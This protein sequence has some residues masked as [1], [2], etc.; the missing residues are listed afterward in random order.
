VSG[1]LNYRIQ[2]LTDLGFKTKELAELM[3]LDS[4]EESDHGQSVRETFPLSD[5]FL[6]VDSW[7][8]NEIDPQVDR[9][10]SAVFGDTILTPTSH[11]RAMHDASSAANNSACLS[12]QV[13]AA[14]TDSGGKLL[15]VGWNDVPKFG[16][17]LYTS[18]DIATG[19]DHRCMAING[20]ICHNDHQKHLFAER[21]VNDLNKSD[22]IGLNQREEFKSAILKSKVRDLIEF[23]RSVHAEMHAI[24]NA[25]QASGDQMRGG[26][27]YCTTYPCHSCARHIVAA[28]LSEVHYIE[29]YRKSLATDLHRDAITEDEND[30]SKLRLLT[31]KGVAP[32]K[33]DDFFKA[34][35]NSRK[36]DGKMALD[37]AINAEPLVKASLEAIPQ[38]EAFITSDLVQKEL[39]EAPR[40]D[41]D[42]ET[43]D[44]PEPDIL[45]ISSRGD[46]PKKPS[47]EAKSEGKVSLAFL[48]HIKSQ[49]EAERNRI[50]SLMLHSVEHLRNI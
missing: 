7:Q 42:E 16:G 1:A 28:G 46:R 47:S 6:K 36:K 24:I 44:Q 9:F 18:D 34:K 45:S 29:P 38:L 49:E 35:P 23:S 12:R 32:R 31:F 2:S 5:F 41:A 3:D 11:E 25:S 10:L 17:G 4:G 40:S 19:K 27:L 26:R 8:D 43:I 48:E 22:L 20:G 33:F 21:I 15:G 37:R 39:I 30:S 50:L 13:G 14:I